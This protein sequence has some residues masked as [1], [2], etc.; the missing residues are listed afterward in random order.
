MK[1]VNNDKSEEKYYSVWLPP[2]RAGYL[3]NIKSTGSISILSGYK[4]VIT[5]VTLQ[6]F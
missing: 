4:K 3:S 5:A 6:C 1:S 2:V